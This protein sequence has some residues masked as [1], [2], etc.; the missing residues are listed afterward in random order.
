MTDPTP[1]PTP[2]PAPAAD[3]ETP[4]PT[5]TPTPA[6]AGAGVLAP[7]SSPEWMQALPEDLRADATLSKYGSLEDFAKGHLETKRVA[8]MKAVPLPGDTDESRKAFADAIRPQSIDAYD[9]GEVAPVLDKTLVDGFREFAFK[10]G[11]PPHMAKE[12]VDFVA[13][14]QAAQIEAANQ[15]S[16]KDVDA[17]KKEYGP[18]Y[19]AKL[20]KVQDMIAA[21]TGT[22]LELGEEDLNR[23]DIKLGSSGL[24]KF[25][26]A[27]HDRIGDLEPAGGIDAPAGFSSVAPEQANDVWNAKV[28]DK[29]WRERATIKGTPEH[30]ES[31]Y[32]QKMIAQH[33]MKAGGG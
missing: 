21:F 12:A 23:A 28:R 30:R 8:S 26:F 33:R 10:T 25:M 3:G 31:E 6:P 19:D 11:L 29:A 9:F 20:A 24:V 7:G 27:L 15:A 17:F 2:T 13:Q 16:L 5:P 32:L 14:A 22:A 4:T 1:T 18:Q